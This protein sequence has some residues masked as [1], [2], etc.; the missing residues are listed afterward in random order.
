[1]TRIDTCDP[2]DWHLLQA[3]LRSSPFH[4]ACPGPLRLIL[5]FDLDYQPC[6]HSW[7]I[8]FVSFFLLLVSIVWSSGG[9]GFHPRHINFEDLKVSVPRTFSAWGVFKSARWNYSNN[10]SHSKTM[11]MSMIFQT[12]L[13]Y[14]S[15][16]LG[17]WTP[18][19]KVLLLESAPWSLHSSLFMLQNLQLLLLPEKLHQHIL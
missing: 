9:P 8:P 3:I 18:S 2:L 17:S 19:N 4:Q 15:F 7:S 6:L 14:S 13:S 1:M 12:I 10:L 5:R 11:P 16:I